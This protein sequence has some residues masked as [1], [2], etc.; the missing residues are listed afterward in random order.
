[1]TLSG[2]LAIVGLIIAV[3]LLFDYTNGFHDAA[4]SIATVVS[5]RVLSPGKAV[6]LAAFFNFVAAFGFP[7]HVASTIGKGLIDIAQVN[8]A[9]I[10]AGLLGAIT[11]NI[12]TWYLGL[13][14]SSSHAL[15][16]GYAGAA[17]AKSGFGVL[18]WSQWPKGWAGT[19]SFIVI[20]PL[21]GMLLGTALMVLVAW[22]FKNF[23]P[24]RVDRLFRVLQVLSASL[25]SLSHGLN[26]AQKTMGIMMAALVT[27]GFMGARAEIPM[28]VILSAHAAIALGTL[29]GGWRIVKT[30]GSRITRLRPVGGF[31]AETGGGISIIIASIFG[32][33]VSTTHTITGAIMGV[34]SAH[35]LSAVRWAVAGRIVWAWILTIPMAALIASLLFGII[36][37]TMN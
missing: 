4:N 22:L 32:I 2:T 13:P 5:T 24:G 31:C 19:I 23:A 16:G 9:V 29:S 34:G 11:W 15:V 28:W 25:Y 6:A 3:A 27:G 36:N 18:L 21:M 30:M 8:F 33:P 26:D 7:T 35:R 10:L 37:L 20:A 17:V 14:T 12:I 1:M